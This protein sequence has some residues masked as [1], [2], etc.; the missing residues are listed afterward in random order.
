MSLFATF[1][2]FCSTL[3]EPRPSGSCSG[4]GSFVSGEIV[5][6]ATRPAT[7]LNFT[8]TCTAGR[9]LAS[10]ALGTSVS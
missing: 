7:R 2:V 5:E 10:S 6:M 4:A 1:L 8:A 9:A 3:R